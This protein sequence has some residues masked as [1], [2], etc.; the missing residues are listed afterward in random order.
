MRTLWAFSPDVHSSAQVQAYRGFFSGSGTTNLTIVANAG[1]GGNT[2]V[3]SFNSSSTAYAYCAIARGFQTDLPD[4]YVFFRINTA[5]GGFGANTLGVVKGVNSAGTTIWELKQ[6]GASGVLDLYYENNL[7]QAG[8]ITVGV[9]SQVVEIYCKPL[10]SGAGILTMKVD[11]TTVYTSSSL[12][13]ANT[14][15]LNKVYFGQMANTGKTYYQDL[16][17][18]DTNGGSL[19]W[20][21]VNT[22]LQADLPT[23]DGT[24][25]NWTADGEGSHYVNVDETTSNDATDKNR[26]TS[27]GNIDL[28]TFPALPSTISTI[29]AVGVMVVNQPVAANGAAYMQGEC[30]IGSTNY[31]TSASALGASAWND[32]C[33]PFFDVDPSTG[34]AWASRSAVDNAQFGVKHVPS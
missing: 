19:T 25:L 23:G 8:A 32:T 21:G 34:A 18:Q 6:N 22:V 26:S 13:F 30:R 28:Y 9:S 17:L 11:G 3:I 31:N 4:L 2:S 10:G 33:L 16:I 24:T 20:L 1:R 29:H 12:T 14:E 7:V 15:G 5:S 27:T